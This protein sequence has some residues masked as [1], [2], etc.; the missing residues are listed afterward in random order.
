MNTAMWAHPLTVQQLSTLQGFWKHDDR[1][2]DDNDENSSGTCWNG[3][4]VIAPQVKELACGE[5]GDGAL[6]SVD[7]IM[8]E[9]RDVMDRMSDDWNR[10]VNQ[11]I[12]QR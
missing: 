3:V 1:T 9:L 7:S 10:R 8:Q 6:A 5:I 2:L 4:R 12:K 11:E